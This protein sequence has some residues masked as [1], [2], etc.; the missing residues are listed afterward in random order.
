LRADLFSRQDLYPWLGDLYVRP[1]YRS[2]G[3]GSALQDFALAEAKK[4][5]YREIYLYS[6]LTGYYERNGWE[7]MGDEMERDGKTVRIYRK[8]FA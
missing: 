8:Y 1:E 2:H 4:R 3:L 7:Y 6:G 5:G